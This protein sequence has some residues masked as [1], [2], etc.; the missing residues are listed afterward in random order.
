MTIYVIITILL[1]YLIIAECTQPIFLC[2]K[3]ICSDLKQCHRCVSWF[4][5]I[6]WVVSKPIFPIHECATD[7]HMHVGFKGWSDDDK[8]L[9]WYKLKSYM[10]SRELHSAPS[11]VYF[12]ES[13]G[14]NTSVQH[15]I[16]RISC[17][18]KKKCHVTYFVNIKLTW[19][20]AW[21]GKKM[22]L[23]VSMGITKT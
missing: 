16:R 1:I 15:K 6:L 22:L 2:K 19:T 8:V 12:D 20:S 17:Y 23:V 18:K 10:V 14:K 5:V 21:P 3:W 13:I 11:R 7:I 9:K 4:C